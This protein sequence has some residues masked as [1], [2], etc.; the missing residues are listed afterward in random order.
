MEPGTAAELNLW[1]RAIGGGASLLTVIGVIV[2]GFVGLRRYR[3]G[4][5]IKAGELLLQMEQ[6][7][8][9]VALTCLRWETLSSYRT[10]VK[11]VLD[12]NAADQAMSDQE[13]QLLAD[14]DRCLRFFYLCTVLH[15]DLRIER[16]VVAR[17]YYWYASLL[18][19]ADQRPE[20]AEYVRV[21]Y[22]RLHEWLLR[23]R[24]CFRHYRDTG[25][26]RE[27]DALPA[28]RVRCG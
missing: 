28:A 10:Q 11:P 23:H 15:T 12:K 5:K 7:F 25:E 16:A 3:H 27:C 19:D 20:L 14:V 2:G 1:I 21:H 6:E 26:W 9:A 13:L 8:R 18:L 24:D 17:S 22:R 4:L